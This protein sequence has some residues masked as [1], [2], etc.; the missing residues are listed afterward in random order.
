MDDQSFE[1][2]DKARKMG[3]LFADV[4]FVILQLRESDDASEAEAAEVLKR[5]AAAGERDALLDCACLMSEDAESDIRKRL[6]KQACELGVKDAYLLY[7][8]CFQE[9][10]AE[11]YYWL[12]KAAASTGDKSFMVEFRTQINM[13]LGRKRGSDVMFAIGHALHGQINEPERTIFQKHFRG[14]TAGTA[15]I[16]PSKYWFGLAYSDFIGPAKQAVDFYETQVSACRKAVN[17]WILV[18]IRKKVVKDV[19]KII[20]EMIWKSRFEALY[21]FEEKPI[22]MSKRAKTVFSATKQN[23][24]KW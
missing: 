21:K 13:Y 6:L 23:T 10:E 18:G 20:G 8:E 2:L 3:Y 17:T 9:S 15:M 7:A 24:R 22:V 19:R 12:G 16:P 1:Y 5:A 14:S 4:M 11:R